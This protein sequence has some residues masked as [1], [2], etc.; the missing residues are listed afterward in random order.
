MILVTGHKGFIGSH[1]YRHILNSG[2]KVRGFDWGDTLNLDG[3]KTVM[4]LGGISST[5]EKNVE[6]IMHQNYDFSVDLLE[7]CIKRGIHFQYS[8]S[9]SLY[10][11]NTLFAEDS[12]V[13][14]KTPYAWSKYM[15]ERYATRKESKIKIQG[16]R[17][18]N[19]WSES[20]EEHKGNQASSY[21]KFT[22]QAKNTGVITLFE[23]SEKYKRDFIHVNKIIHY[24]LKFLQISESG[25]WNL[26]TGKCKSF[27]DVAN[28]VS[29][30]Y[31]CTY[32]Y[33]DMPDNLKDSYQEYTCADMSKTKKSLGGLII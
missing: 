14:P 13:D 4:H 11:K 1:L 28:E 30:N 32:K 33:I 9:A 24:H 21:F 26:G 10:G 29:K 16:F 22:Q 18:F 2:I 25:V 7:T 23:N 8:S 17:Y 3:V 20:G 27:L 31:P 5:T 12:P 19:V 6:K 15:F